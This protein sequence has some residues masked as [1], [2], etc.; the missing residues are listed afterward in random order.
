MNIDFNEEATPNTDPHQGALSLPAAAP[1]PD[2][3]QA[4]RYG[5]F[6][7]SET[8]PQTY[9]EMSRL[10][11]IANVPVDAAMA[12]PKEVKQQVRMGS[13]DF[14]TLAQTS[15]A[16]A[17]VLANIDSAKLAH[18]DVNNMS[19][20]ETALTYMG[21]SGKA[22]G[23]DLLAAGAKLIDA[24]QPFTTSDQDLATLYKNDPEGLKRQREQGASM[25]LSRFARSQT[26][27][28]NATLEAIPQQAKD[29]YGNLK[30]E[31]TDTDNAAYLS[32]VKMISD[33]IRSMPTTAALAL[34]TFLTRGAANTARQQ[35]ALVEGA[36]EEAI[37]QAGIDAATKMATQFGAASEGAVGYG[38]Q[39]NQTQ[40]TLEDTPTSTI[41]FSHKARD[42]KPGELT[43]GTWSSNQDFQDLISQG[44][45]PDAAKLYLSARGAEQSGALAGVVDTLTNAV[46]GHFLGRIIGDGGKV[47]PRIGKGLANE[48]GVETVQS[49]GEQ[50]GENAVLQSTIKPDTPLMD[51]V[52]ESM[53]QGGVVGGLTGGTFAG[54]MGGAQKRKD[55]AGQSEQDAQMIE[56]LNKLSQASQVLARSPETF[57]N[58]VQQASAN[59]TVN[60]IYIEANALMQSGL[61]DQ[62]AAVSP[63]VAAQLQTAAQTGGQIAI[64]IEE[65]T[66][67]I[68]PTELSQPLLDHLKLD[69]EGY[70]RAEAAAYMQSEGDQLRADME[71]TLSVKLQDL[72]FRQSRDGLKTQFKTQLD[73]LNHHDSHVNEA[74]ATHLANY[75]GVMSERMGMTP[76]EMYQQFPVNFVSELAPGQHYDQNIP[77]LDEVKS[78]LDEQGV[79]HSIGEKD[80]LIT[81]SKIEVPEGER[82][83]GKGTAAMQAITDYADRTGQHVALSPSADFGGNKQRLVA[84]YKRFGFVENKGKNRAFSTSESMYRQADGQNVNVAI[85][86]DTRTIEDFAKE[87][88]GVTIDQGALKIALASTDD[89]NILH[90]GAEVNRGSF[91]PE[92]LTISLFKDANLSTFL[93][94]T[95]HFFLETHLHLA[96]QLERMAEDLGIDALSVGQRS[97]LD[98]A[99]ATLAWF[100]VSDINTWYSMD[101]EQKRPFHEQFARGFESY[102]YESKA[103]S[104]ALAPLFQRFAQWLR[105]VYQSAKA[106]NVEINDELRG[107]FDRMLASEAEIA[108]AQQARSMMPL[109]ASPEDASMTPEEFAIYQESL[110]RATDASQDQLQSRLLRDLQWLRNARAKAMKGLQKD[111]KEKRREEHMDVKRQVMSQP[112]YRAW[113]LLTGKISDDN[114]IPAFDAK[115]KS[116]PNLVE[117]DKDSL[118]AAIAKLGG[119]NKAE[120]MTT[121]DLD[122]AYKPYSG[123]FGKPVWRKEGGLSI[124]G[125]VE[126][127]VE[128][129]YLPADAHG[130]ADIRD[131]EDAFDAELRGNKQYSTEYDYNRKAGE[132]VVNPHAL[133][134]VRLD[135]GELLAAGYHDDVLDVLKA[136]KMTTVKD[137]FDP[138]IVANLVLDDQGQPE[139]HSGDELL[140]ALVAARPPNEVIEDQTDA[141]MLE[142]Y[143]DIATPQALEKAADVAVHNEY[144]AHV[145]ATEANALAEITGKPRVLVNAAKALAAEII[146]RKKVRHVTPGQFTQAEA[147]AAKSADKYFKD[148]DFINAEA[149]KKNQLFNLYAAKAAMDAQDEVAKIDKFF[150]KVIGGKDVDLAKLRDMDVVNAARAV[151]GLFGYNGKAK[152]GLEYLKSVE[153]YDPQAYQVL[154][155]SVQFAEAMAAS[156]KFQGKPTIRDLT[157]EQLRELAEEIHTLWHL[158]KRNKTI[159][160]DGQLFNRELVA[161][162]LGFRLNE[163]GV[164]DVMPGDFSAVTPGEERM[165]RFASLK[166]VL[167]RVESWVDLKDGLNKMGPF[168][169]YLWTPVREAADRYR[170]DKIGY[171]KELRAA[172]AAIAPTFKTTNLHAPELNYTFGKDSGG[173]A[174]NELLH[175]I[176]HTGNDSNKRKLLLGRKWADQRA[177]GTVDTTK[178][179]IF[180]QRM[181]H[182]GVLTQAHFDFAQTIWDLLDK[183]KPLAQKAHRDAFGRYFTEVTANEFMTPWGSYRGGYIPASVD[184]RIVKDMALKKLVE[185]GKDSMAHAFPSASKGFTM[186][187]VD[188]NRPLMLDLRTLPQHLDKVLMFSHLEMPVRDA[189]K[190]LNTG[191]VKSG[192]NRQDPAAINDML[193]PWLNRTAHQQVTTPISG[194]PWMTRFLNTLRNRTSMAA[195]FANVSNTAQQIT[196]FSLAAVKV[197]PSRLL[198]ATADYMKAPKAFTAQIADM[199]M[200]MAHR[201]ENEVGAMMNDI[202]Q[203]L[204]NPT[205]FENAQAWTKQHQF[206]MQSAVDNVMGPIIW[207]GAFDQA[208]EENYDEKA[209]VRIADAVVRQTQGSSQ[210]EDVSR[211]ETGDAWHRLFTLFAG[212]FNMQANLL[213][214]EFGK[215]SQEMG[216]R[217]NKGKGFMI[218]VLGF[219]V[220]ALVAQAIAEG[221]RGGPGDDDKD[222]EYLD[223]WLMSLFV[224][225]PI[226][227]ATAF[228]PF[229]GQVANSM[230]AR[231]NNNP[232]D[233][234]V[235]LSPVISALESAGGAV[236]DAID[237][238]SG[239]GN[240]KQTVRDVATLISLSVGLPASVAARPL[241]Y[242][243][244][245]AQGKIDP[246]GPIDLAR[247][248]ITGAPSPESR[249]H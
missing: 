60:Q 227:N 131:L 248:L 74:Y 97:I 236:K 41:E 127:L 244:G 105:R 72:A 195:M 50:L 65:Y 107:V 207:K 68:A 196:G 117:P 212:Y 140:R 218:F 201:M 18:D 99:N 28:A 43:L 29:A 44:Y 14:N 154:S 135:L 53:I 8:D 31:T 71:T 92:S 213:G 241:G 106:L 49:G 228:V 51:N 166:A 223:D 16:T 116:N 187:R 119:L 188:Y 130:K 198:S 114:K 206:F 191:A 239:E 15:P 182:E 186:A 232:I 47:L 42:V 171:L 163:I 178:W 233:D 115:T 204:L 26:Q 39:A 183:T 84:F 118:F 40:Q 209:A 21:A 141:R 136:R 27:Q 61:A 203:I 159:E 173:V 158:S 152:T 172:F 193:I 3:A 238:A 80:G 168:R 126:A 184:S 94:E 231:F 103:P 20:V 160:I 12:N 77:K 234:R 179:D 17:A 24:A 214:T 181:I 189:T 87:D 38:Q 235:S 217:K 83:T 64:P 202:D 30:Y 143:G 35:A 102:L 82:G 240:A 180:I 112:V 108:Q 153:K 123:V 45:D 89:N 177:D 62:L 138:E 132:Q 121:W 226:R 90:Q 59:G 34:T 78:K 219:Y 192:L 175:A 109:F 215:V 229:V 199:S 161:E 165:M 86:P 176:L 249:Q 247:G 81:L 170:A 69:P 174:M 66:T 224:Y 156:A 185:E 104:L 9:A 10:A 13:I 155:Q 225:G 134:A 73:G 91:N 221:F 237:I 32:P 128:H 100:G 95:G 129:G 1:V 7:A 144:R 150:K 220:P 52:F 125:M 164:P 133:T 23:H 151:L 93:H 148:G 200:Y 124:D 194:M 146:G 33:M 79:T 210:A 56:Q 96:S 5:F 120:L 169:R 149:E 101:L 76:E 222:G 63:S 85:K 98:D 157:V 145:V 162:E 25:F 243:A 147:R 88:R 6:A 139:F 111:A 205:L 137:G 46:G 36:T 245:A 208:L 2:Q 242:L 57:E 22:G 246:T 75:F 70:S 58:L 67:Q 113:S 55:Q 190:L 54:I 211:M 142:K 48:G 122:P 167:R 216:L 197:S 110:I 230:I 4:A 11:K 37:R 19:D